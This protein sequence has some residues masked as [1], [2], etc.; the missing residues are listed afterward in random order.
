VFE[1][2]GGVDYRL[3]DLA[4]GGVYFVGAGGEVR[5]A[6]HFDHLT[7]GHAASV[8]PFSV[9]G[10]AFPARRLGPDVA[11][12]GFHDLCGTPRSAA[13]Y[14]EIARLFHTVLLSGLPVL[15]PRHEAAARRFVHL[16][17]EFYDRRV[18]LV[19]SADAPLI[20]L[21]AGGLLDF[22]YERVRSRLIEMQSSDY[23]A[24]PARI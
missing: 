10:R 14:I 8:E 21:Y 7:G 12:F 13:D 23:L 2:D 5:L 1:L 17:D 15:G 11:W 20:D 4:Q 3:R 9:N 19:I 16:I 22:P 6:E 18:K 24:A